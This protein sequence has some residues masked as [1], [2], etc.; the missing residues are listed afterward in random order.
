MPHNGCDSVF[1]VS[2]VFYIAVCVHGQSL[3]AIGEVLVPDRPVVIAV[4]LSLGDG[5]T[6]TNADNAMPGAGMSSNPSQ[7][8]TEIYVQHLQAPAYADQG[9]I[10]LNALS[11]DTRLEAI[12]LGRDITCPG[13]MRTQGIPTAQND[14]IQLKGVEKF[15]NE[16]LLYIW[17]RNT[18]ETQGMGQ[19]IPLLIQAIPSLP[20]GGDHLDTL[21][22][23]ELFHSM[24]RMI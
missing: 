9:N 21:R 7:V 17:E 16:I 3:Q 1:P 15:R 19:G 24:K 2:K 5:Q 4:H 23:T 22:N 20:I 14:T 18:K 6:V 13:F 8:S 10:P 12:T 11:D